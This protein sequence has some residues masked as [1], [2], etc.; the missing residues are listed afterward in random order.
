MSP[1]QAAGAPIDQRSDLFS[2]GVLLAELFTGAHPFRKS[3]GDQIEYA[4]LDDSPRLSGE[5][6]ESLLILIRRLLSRSLEL[7]Y[8]SISEVVTDLERISQ[9]LAERERSHAESEIPLIGR[10]QE[11]AALKSMLSAAIAGRGALVMIGGEP[12]IGK[13]HL[14]RAVIE[15]ARRRGALGILGH[16]SDMEGTPPYAPFIEMLEYI[17]RMVPRESFRYSLGDQASEVARMM[18]ELREMYPEIPPAIQ[19]PPEHERRY[20]FNAF[21]SFVERAASVTPLVIVFEDVQWADETT[22]LLLQ[23]HAQTL[24]SSAMLVICTYRDTEL[25]VRRP[26][27]TALETLVRSKLCSRMPLRRLQLGGV[28]GMLTALSGQQP[29]PSLARAVYEET[30]GNPFFVEEVFRHL[31]EEGMIFDEEGRWRSDLRLDNLQVPES[32]RLVL[33]RRLARLSE[34][35]RRVLTTAAVIGRSFSLHLLEHLEVEEPEG[36]ID[37]LEE[38]EAA[39]LV[40]PEPAGR[41]TRYRFVHE[42]VRQTLAESLSMPRRQRL[43][44]RIAEAIEKVYSD[45]LDSQASQL[46]HHLYQAGAAADLEKTSMY[47]LLAA[48]QASAK[49]GHEEALE[50]IE[51]ALSLREDH[52]DRKTAELLVEKASTLRS[53]AR[54]DEAVAAYRKAIDINEAIGD[55]EKLAETSIALAYLQAWRHDPTGAG[56]TMERAHQ[57]VLGQSPQV[58]SR[59]LSMRA[60]IMSAA[61]DPAAA[62]VM[63]ENARALHAS[64]AA[65]PQEPHE[66]LEAIHYYQSFQLQKVRA[67]C[68]RVAAA[69]FSN[70][71]LWSACSVEFY[72]IWAEM[73]CGCPE[74]GSAMIAPAM[75][76]AEKIGHHGAIW[77]LKIAA[78]IA[79]AARGNIQAAQDQTIGA[80][81]FGAAH[82]VGWNFATS[83]QRGHFALWSG[84]VAEAEDLYRHG[85]KLKERSYLSDFAEACLF[86]AWAET[87]DPRAAEAWKNRTWNLPTPGQINSLGAWNALERTVVGIAHLRRREDLSKLRRLTEELLLTG[88]WTYT[89][90]F[91]LESIA[92]ITSAA[93]EDWEAA[94]T[95]HLTAIHQT[96][97]APYRH[98]QPVAREWYARMLVER[99]RAADREKANSLLQKSIQLY[100]SL[101]QLQRAAQAHQILAEL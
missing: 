54:P 59:V 81:E 47:L 92:G 42:L 45:R 60:A 75:E 63:F 74:S 80:W 18:P 65:A 89:I 34:S 49:T 27:A 93:D 82:D 69:C 52:A 14:A 19:L 24:S 77:A 91:P 71:D 72:G 8:Q 2:Y 94:E 12:G 11:F 40:S 26:F 44:F 88:A 37:A 6:P 20:L 32:V 13:S 15:E 25:A 97:T 1:E 23:H 58:I 84:N 16:C 10:E 3:P 43:H 85:L 67:A 28:K 61:G 99:K 5:L 30:D 29:P 9:M 51:V 100:E 83:L 68:P 39:H 21:R 55:F 33:G 86:A 95:H 98:L 78:A 87:G 90:L 70:G 22:L 57:C 73:Y 64:S 4:D 48:R 31:S 62:N 36:A 76:K 46:A 7:R 50:Y 38:A 53:L 17:T 56:Y 35:T 66:M 96:D 79:S 41:D 101:G